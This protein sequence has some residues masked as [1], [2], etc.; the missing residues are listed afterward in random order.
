MSSSN[1]DYKGNVMTRKIRIIFL[2]TFCYGCLFSVV[3]CSDEVSDS[4]ELPSLPGNPNPD[5]GTDPPTDDDPVDDTPVGEIE[6]TGFWV[7]VQ[8]EQI[9]L[10]VDNSE[11]FDSDCFIDRDETD[12]I[13][14]KCY[15]DIM[16]GDLYVHNLE[17]Q[18]N[19]PPGLCQYVITQ[20][21]W[22]WNYGP[23]R[24]PQTIEI[25]IDASGDNPVV[26]SCEADHDGIGGPPVA[27]NL[28]PELEDV[29]NTEGPRCVYD[30]SDQ[31]LPNCCVGDYVLTKNTDDGSAVSTEVIDAS[32]GNDPMACMSPHI[33]NG[34]ATFS[35]SGVP[36]GRIQHVPRDPGSNNPVGLNES[37]NLSS[38]ASTTQV[39]FSTW[40]NYFEGNTIELP[41]Q[42]PHYHE[43]FYDNSLN[44]NRPFFMDPVTDVS[45]T[46]LRSAGIGVGY[47]NSAWTFTCADSALEV[48]QRIKFYIR[49]WNTLADFFLY[50]TSGGMTYNP[51]VIGTEGV[52]CAYDTGFGDGCND[53]SDIGDL[54][55]SA[56]GDYDYT[57]NP[58]IQ[59][60]NSFFPNINY[61]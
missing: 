29:G 7:N 22:N 52:D 60:Y 10:F 43:D 11:S 33:A 58:T 50:Q 5:P 8:S 9:D 13:D 39:G 6:E 17:L 23:G 49:E 37:I 19:A 51:D 48:K 55:N 36:V 40:A 32:W 45:G 41:M 38:N 47:D 3:G 25:D 46:R 14:M 24:G 28:H 57:G 61:Q 27:C 18:Y 30:H 54:L 31:G 4:R 42:S 35:P 16:E 15:L 53:S 56:G 59:E 44:S 2:L 26:T 34:W 21:A 20:P 1:F 12:F